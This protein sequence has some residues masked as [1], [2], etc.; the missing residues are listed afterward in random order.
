MI[1]CSWP[2]KTLLRQERAINAS[3]LYL[4]HLPTCYLSTAS[5]ISFWS[6]TAI[7]TDMSIG[8]RVG[9]YTNLD[10]FRDILYFSSLAALPGCLAILSH[11]CTSLFQNL[12]LPP[13]LKISIS[14]FMQRNS[15]LLS[16]WGLN[17]SWGR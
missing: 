4:H 15:S 10:S 11:S 2:C 12:Y 9:H 1:P 3:L 8:D 17:S 16:L 5:T 6:C 13:T 14:F 7:L